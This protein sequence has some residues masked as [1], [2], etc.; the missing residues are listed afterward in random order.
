MET[1]SRATRSTGSIMK[2]PTHPA[3]FSHLFQRRSLMPVATALLLA[4]SPLS[5]YCADPDLALPE[6]QGNTDSALVLQVGHQNAAHIT[7]SGSTKAAQIAQAGAGN[8]ASIT[9]LGLADQAIA[10]QY[11]AGNSSTIYQAGNNDKAATAQYGLGN[12]AYV[13]QTAGNVSAQVNELGLGNKTIL[14]QT[15]PG[16]TPVTLNVAGIGKTTLYIQ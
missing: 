10:V 7:Q 4:A 15:H 16:A 9:Q 13:G 6:L 1:M 12:Q 5:A 8:S 11:G 3:T 2:K 14:L